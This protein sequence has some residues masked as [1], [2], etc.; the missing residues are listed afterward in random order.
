MVKPR[1]QNLK[2]VLP[3][4]STFLFCL[5]NNNNNISSI[6]ILLLQQALRVKLGKLS[7]VIVVVIVKSEMKLGILVENQY[8]ALIIA[9]NA[10]WCVL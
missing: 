4:K 10:K 9:S 3:N 8:G 6:G 1:N 7:I 2:N 5:G